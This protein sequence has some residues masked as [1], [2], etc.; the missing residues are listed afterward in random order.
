MTPGNA[1]H[2]FLR[3]HF[4][5]VEIPRRLALSRLHFGGLLLGTVP[6]AKIAKDVRNLPDAILIRDQNVILAPGEPIGLVE[7]FGIALDELGFAVALLSSEQRQVAR[8]LFGYD[9]VA[10]G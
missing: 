1:E 4:L 2:A 3:D 5:P 6:G 9:D 7:P 8:L 10:I